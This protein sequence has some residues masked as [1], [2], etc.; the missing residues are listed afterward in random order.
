M[1]ADAARPELQ[2]FAAA[3]LSGVLDLE[4]FACHRCSTRPILRA[5][6]HDVMGAPAADGTMPQLCAECAARWAAEEGADAGALA[7]IDVDA[8]L[9]AKVAAAGGVEALCALLHAG[10]A[11][12][13]SVIKR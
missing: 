5:R 11:A 10:L 12:A 1:A 3:V 9:H 4:C 2:A 6:A 7:T 13:E 8:T